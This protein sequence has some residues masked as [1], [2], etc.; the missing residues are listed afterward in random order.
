[1]LSQ[2][3]G[4]FTVESAPGEG[5][6]FTLYLPELGAAERAVEHTNLPHSGAAANPPVA[7][8]SHPGATILVVDDEPVVLEVATRMLENGGFRVRQASDGADALEAVELHGP[9]Q[10]VLTDLLMRRIG[11]SEL[12]RRLKERWPALPVLYMSGYSADELYRQGAI[13]PTGELIQKPFD[14]ATL[15]ASVSA[16]LARA[17]ARAAITR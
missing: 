3:D 11:G 6:T 12:A 16:A 2:N 8:P 1:V 17:D 15:V 5:A 13:D 10:L 14:S 7:D 9:P 4:Y